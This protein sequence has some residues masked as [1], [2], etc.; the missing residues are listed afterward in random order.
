[1]GSAL[2]GASPAAHPNVPI[3]LATAYASDYLTQMAGR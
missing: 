3:I 2:S 1:M